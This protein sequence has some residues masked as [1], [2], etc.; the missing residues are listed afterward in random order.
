M[1]AAN[2]T[3]F[4]LGLIPMEFKIQSCDSIQLMKAKNRISFFTVSL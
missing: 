2:V 1:V 3:E 4:L